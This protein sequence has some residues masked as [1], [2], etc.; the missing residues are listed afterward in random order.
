[1]KNLVFSLT[2]L[3]LMLL[4]ASMVQAQHLKDLLILDEEVEAVM[5]I[6]PGLIQ[7]SDVYRIDGFSPNAIEQILAFL[8]EKEVDELKIVVPSKPGAIIFNS[9]SIT[10][11]NMEEWSA[12]VGEWNRYVKTRVVIHGEEVFSDEEGRKL[13]QCLEEATGLEFMMQ[14]LN[15]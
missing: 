14:N 5:Q 9:F 6:N 2:M 12:G 11:D 13:K 1:M 3:L 4:S 15:L 10:P 7:Q 8:K